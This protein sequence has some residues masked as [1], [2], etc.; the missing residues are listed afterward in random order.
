MRTILALN[1]KQLDSNSLIISYL[2]MSNTLN[3]VYFKLIYNQYTFEQNN[4]NISVAG[5][6]FLKT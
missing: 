4:I 3:K 2:F 6:D 5:P 1:L